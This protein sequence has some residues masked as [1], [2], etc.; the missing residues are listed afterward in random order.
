LLVPGLFFG[1]CSSR[2]IIARPGV[3]PSLLALACRRHCSSRAYH[4]SSQALF[5]DCSP[6]A[7]PS[8]LLVP[9]LFLR[10]AERRRG[11]GRARL[12]GKAAAADRNA[13]FPGPTPAAARPELAGRV[14]RR[15]GFLPA[16]GAF[17]P[18]RAVC[19]SP[20]GIP[21]RIPGFAGHAP[22]GGQP[23]ALPRR[24]SAPRWQDRRLPGSTLTAA[25]PVPMEAV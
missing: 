5:G 1:D 19:R 12:G 2:A 7:M 4:C 17:S 3:S 8:S 14:C 11:R 21:P 22:R 10:S 24:V 13:G 6:R 25:W 15:P 16:P 23:L 9:G 20:R 18:G